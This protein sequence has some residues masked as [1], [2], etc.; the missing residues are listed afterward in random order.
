[1]EQKNAKMCVQW[2]NPKTVLI[3]V[4]L[5]LLAGI[6]T[7]SILRER[8]V[9]K[10]DDVTTVIGRGKISYQPDT[11]VIT[12][13]VQIDKAFKAEEALNQLNNSMGAVV[14]SAKALGIPEADIQTQAY[15]LSPHYDYQGSGGGTTIPSGYDANQQVTIKA[16]GID[17]NPNLV[18]NVIEKSSQ[19]GANQVVGVTF[20]VSNLEELKQKARVEAIADAKSKSQGLAKAAGVRN[21]GRVVSWYENVIA[22]PDNQNPYYSSGVGG[23]TDQAAKPAPAPQVPSGTQDII[24]EMGL[25]YRIR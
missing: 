25:N 9:N 18:S 22:S 20:D 3:F 23:G 5:F 19:A 1:M 13:G 11:A 10:T 14:A 8:F 6:I 4:S 17:K 2:K 16:R 12:L 21:L 7:V 24:I 15:S